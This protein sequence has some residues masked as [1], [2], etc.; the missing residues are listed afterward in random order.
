MVNFQYKDFYGIKDLE[1]IVRILRAP[2]GC[3]DRKSVV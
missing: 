3:P 2:G 1:E